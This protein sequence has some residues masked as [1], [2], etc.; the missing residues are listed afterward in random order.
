MSIT[1]EFSRRLTLPGASNTGV[2]AIND[3]DELSGA[4]C[5][6]ATC[7]GFTYLNGQFTTVN[8]SAS[9]GQIINLA[10]NNAG[11]LAAAYVDSAGNFHGAVSAIGPFAYVP[12][13]GAGDVSVLDLSTSLLAAELLWGLR[14]FTRP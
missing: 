10:I 2:N 8:F 12:I 7:Q 13:F 14:P 1:L 3:S 5:A 11:R 4:E 9:L 6:A